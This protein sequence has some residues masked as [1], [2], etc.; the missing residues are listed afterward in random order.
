MY[1]AP[2][3]LNNLVTANYDLLQLADDILDITGNQTAY[4]IFVRS[5]P[6]VIKQ[7]TNLANLLLNEASPVGFLQ[8]IALET[9]D[10]GQFQKIA[11]LGNELSNELNDIRVPVQPFGTVVTEQE[12]DPTIDTNIPLWEESTLE[13]LQRNENRITIVNT[14][15]LVGL[16]GMYEQSAR[17]SYTTTEDIEARKELLNQYYEALVEDDDTEIVIQQVKND[18]DIVKTRTEQV[19]N[20]QAQNLPGV[21]TLKLERPYSAKMIAYEL[22]GEFIKNE[23]QLNSYADLIT[24]LNRSQVAHALVGEIKVLEIR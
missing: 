17:D 12:Y 13:R 2:S 3:T 11:I 7:P 9:N 1:N 24:G 21:V 18:L 14:F 20:E 4:N 19:L 22:Y 16:T 23:T 6:K 15:R 10:F 8:T 5:L